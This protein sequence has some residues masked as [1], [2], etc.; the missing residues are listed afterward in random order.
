MR[1]AWRMLTTSH[2]ELIDDVADGK[3]FIWLGSGISR[4]QVPDL[5]ALMA[6]VLRYLRD[7]AVSGEPDSGNHADS[8]L[9]ILDTYLPGERERYEANPSTWK[10]I[11]LE[12][13]RDQYSRVL[14]VGV[15]GKPNDYLLIEAADLPNVFGDPDLQPGPTHFVLAMLISE[16]VINNLASGNWDGLVEKAL[17]DISGTDSL[18]DVYVDVDDPR[19]AHG[20]AE[21]AKFHG[22]AVLTL[23]EEVKYRDKIIAT[24]AQISKLHSHDAFAHMRDH[25][26]DLATRMRSLVL[27]L[28]VQDSD[29]L[30]IIQGATSRSAW[31]WDSAHPAYL[32]AEPVMLP[33]QRDVLEVA[34]GD[35]FGRERRSIVQRSTLGAYAGPT[36]A[37]LLIEVLAS[38]LIAAL[39]RHADLPAGMI[40]LLE[41]GVRRVVTQI[42]VAF[43]RDELSIATFLLSGYSDF[44][45]TY[46]GPGTVGA[47]RYIPFVRGTRSQLGTDISVMA[48]GLDLLA[49]AVGLFGL[50]EELGRWSMSLPNETLG[51]RILLSSTRNAPNAT[52]IVVRGAK[53]AIAAMASDDWTSSPDN[54][55]L[56]QMEVG[57]LA[58]SR[59]PGGRIG[60][61][62][63]L[64][65][66]RELAWGELSDSVVDVE[67]LM[68]RFETGAGL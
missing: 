9:E 58:S 31:R 37:A 65:K 23:R 61:G 59:S 5:V 22:C 51:S 25:L 67:E 44:L 53:E 21:I 62:R 34:Y 3:R 52:V 28:S 35:D 27:G 7:K 57:S 68:T 46:L 17:A 60:R 30:A 1:D 19:H 54:M 26:L 36:T 29:L 24:T 16:G 2:P 55:V 12:H 64:R 8:L 20:H 32:F 50:G 33:S 48:M 14:G 10:P 49:V 66:R 45:R 63:K 39:H 11:D 6:R 43:G 13:L 47:A 42:I 41:P 56:L 40:T 4:K 38:K 15:T 18:L